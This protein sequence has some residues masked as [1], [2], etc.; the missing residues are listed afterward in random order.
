MS[1]K[2]F[3]NDQISDTNIYGSDHYNYL[4]YTEI[5]LNLLKT[6]RRTSRKSLNWRYGR[7]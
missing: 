3:K 7:L 2:L 5:N 6:Q 4:K 1:K